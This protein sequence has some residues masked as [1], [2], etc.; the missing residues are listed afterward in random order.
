MIWQYAVKIISYTVTKGKFM[1]IYLTNTTAECIKT[2]TNLISPKKS[3][4]DKICYVFCQDKIALN[5]ELEIA[6]RFGGFFG[7]EVLTFKRYISLNYN[8]TNILSK[9]ASVM[10]IRKIINELANN[11]KCF[12]P[13]SY[14]PN[15][16]LTIFETISQLESA[17]VSPDTLSEIL[18]DDKVVNAAL[19]NKI[20]D[21]YLIFKAYNEYLNNN[22]LLDGNNY[23]SLAPSIIKNDENLKNAEV[24]LVGF[25]SA[26]KQRTDIIKAIKE[27]TDNLSAVI[28][29]DESGSEIYTNETFNK[30]KIIDPNATIIPSSEKLSNEVKLI[31]KSLFNLKT[32]S[33]DF[34]P[35][36]TQNVAVY[37]ASTPSAE[38][39]II[40]KEIFNEVKNGKRYKEI[41]VSVGNVKEYAPIVKK[42]FNE[43]N[44]PYYIDNKV[45]LL[46]HPISSYILNYLDL[47]RKGLTVNDFLRFIS[48]GIFS[49]NKTLTDSLKNY[50][51]KYALT[52]SNLKKPFEYDEVNL[53]SYE[54]IR[55]LVYTCY[56]LCEKAKTVKEIVYAVKKMLEITKAFENIEELGNFIKDAK[57]YKIADVNDKVDDKI[58]KVLNEIEL[59]L[60]D[61]S[62]SILDFK[63]IFA[64]GVAGAKIGVIPL[65]N[66]AVFIGECGDVKT[67]NAKTL[68]FMGLSVDV[69]S[70]KSDT[71]L[72]NDNDLNKLEELKVI[73][74]PKIRIVNER[75]KET[76]GTALMAFD[77]RLVLSY[78]TSNSSGD[79]SLKSEV[80]NYILKAFNLKTVKKD[81]LKNLEE[82]SNGFVGTATGVKEILKRTEGNLSENPIGREVTS[83]FYQAIEELGLEGVKEKTDALLLGANAEKRLYTLKGEYFK[84]NQTSASALEKYFSCPYYAYCENLLKLKD[85]ETGEMQVYETGTMLHSLIE[86]YVKEIDK[87]EDQKSSNELVT[88]LI[89]QI[90]NDEKY[91][92]YL[93]KPQ[94]K[95][96][97]SQLKK[98]GERVCYAVYK[99]IKDSMFK[100]YLTEVPFNDNSE[101]KAIKLNTK[102]GEYK[103][104][105]KI[106]RVDKYGNNVRIVDYKSGKIDASN[107]SFYTGRKLQLYLYLNTFLNNGFNPAGTYYFPIHDKFMETGEKNYVMQGRTVDNADVLEATDINI[108]QNKKS[109]HV[110]IKITVT[111]AT[112]KNSQ[113]LT[114]NEMKRYLEYA[115]KVS[116]NAV[117]EINSGFIKAT[118]YEKACDYCKFGG[119]CGFDK[120]CSQERKAK[121]VTKSTIIEA[122]LRKENKESKDEWFG[123]TYYP[124]IKLHKSR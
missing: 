101:F 44:I 27:V 60:G 5:Q 81:S 61:S 51:L 94:Y 53:D 62:I 55:S 82:S 32:F 79:V 1:K 28:L 85:S 64:S 26:T 70:V 35:L 69:P 67:K 4:S 23:L 86:L 114:Q 65:F 24:I 59:I 41:A 115:V 20:S 123:K 48:S 30:L 7:V 37:E 112:Y 119:M 95:F 49:T 88:K 42:V 87:V 89:E 17:T 16:A 52:R 68:Y 92:R 110:S 46:E 6:N 124:A 39:E 76:L 106:D 11:L 105:G 10:I 45:T 18:N 25:N 73:V 31:K 99:S 57:E 36:N 3:L 8:N 113:T 43:Y 109:E 56:S 90:L 77:N 107:E 2:A 118:P 108:K 21:I 71:A 78:S 50:V 58:L 83:A 14:K 117:D 9:E 54:N 93:N 104:T 19:K 121:K 72:L 91:F 100:P 63:N 120:D 122:V 29:A 97:F 66:D 98:E 47:V 40:A 22:S 103:I 111:G 96:I 38:V 13:K 116:E 75:E 15:L 34:K 12:N 80:I 102:N 33:K 84:D 74:E